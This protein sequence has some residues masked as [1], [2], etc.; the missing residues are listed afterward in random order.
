MPRSI[1]LLGTV[2]VSTLLIVAGPVLAQSTFRASDEGPGELSN[3]VTLGGYFEFEYEDVEAGNESSPNGSFDAHRTILFF[4][5]QPHQRLRLFSE[6]EIEH[7]GRKAEFEFEPEEL[8]GQFEREETES[9]IKLE[10]AWLEFALNENHNFRGGIDLIPLGRLN[11][12]HDGNLRDFV[13]RPRTDE[14]LIPTTWFESGLSINGSLT[15]TI[16]YHAGISNGINMLRKHDIEEGVLGTRSEFDAMLDRNLDEQDRSGSKALW[17]RLTV[18]PWLGTK[19]GLSGYSADY[20]EGNKSGNDITFLALDLN[21][22]QGPWEFKGE[23]VDVDKDQRTTSEVLAGDVNDDGDTDDLVSGLDGAD[24]GYLEIAYHFFPDGW[25]D[26]WFARGFDN[27]T[28]TAMARYEDLSFDETSTGVNTAEQDFSLISLGMNYR[29]IERMAFKLSYDIE[30]EDN[31][32]VEDQNRFG[33][34][35]VLGF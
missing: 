14:L 24:G 22:R 3:A 4:G 30:D 5:A 7:G 29:P 2:L 1:A 9:E 15:R 31:A 10:Q 13:F 12:N 19:I 33:F 23:Y 8:G 18:T 27:P 6:L 20:G 21:H 17:G 28:F 32:G 25:Y 11:L 26:A 34:G 16:G 35:L